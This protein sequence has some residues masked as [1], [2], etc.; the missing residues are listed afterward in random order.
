MELEA[1]RAEWA[2]QNA[3]IE[4]GLTLNRRWLAGQQL[5]RARS[6][7][8]RHSRGLIVEAVIG[9]LAIAWLG[10]FIFDHF[11]EPRFLVPALLLDVYCIAAL[12]DIVRQVVTARDVDP[13]ESI[14]AFQKRIELLRM[15]A[16]RHVQRILALAVLLWTPLLIVGLKAVVGLDAWQLFG[17]GYLAANALVGVA[18]ILVAILLARRLAEQAGGAQWFRRLLDDIAGDRLREARRYVDE[19]AEFEQGDAAR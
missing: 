1:F 15:M 11:A 8:V 6:S 13:A 3:R 10:S 14:P 4:A 7:L 9:L 2:A 19:L 16:I 5:D 18:M 17:A 12:A